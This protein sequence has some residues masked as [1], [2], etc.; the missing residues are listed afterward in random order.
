MIGVYSDFDAQATLI[1]RPAWEQ[2][3]HDL[4]KSKAIL[5]YDRPTQEIVS[6][7]YAVRRCES[8]MDI[9]RTVQGLFPSRERKKRAKENIEGAFDPV[10]IN[11]AE[12]GLLCPTLL[13]ERD[14]QVFRCSGRVSVAKP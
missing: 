4:F 6:A 8:T 14:H 9:P 5:I 7:G 13:G 1:L 3:L 2:G 10:L 11:H 12:E